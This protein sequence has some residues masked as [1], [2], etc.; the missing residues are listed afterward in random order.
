MIRVLVSGAGKMGATMV[1]GLAA[2]ADLDVAGIV[3]KLAGDT[4]FRGPSGELPLYADVHAAID[5]TKPDVVV[6]FTN[7]AWTPELTAAALPRGVR[8]VI[9]T[10]GLPQAYVDALSQECRERRVGG[11]VAA[12]FAL[13][14]VLMMH[15]AATA[16]RYFEAAEII[17]LHHDQKVDAPSGT[18][19]ATARSMLAARDGRAF[20]RNE[21]ELEPLAGARSAAV[22]GVTVHS[23]R[24]AGLVA[25]QEVIFGGRGQTLTIRHD[26]TGRDSFVPGVALAVREVMKRED[27]VVGLG[28]LL[29]LE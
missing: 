19:L 18:A 10:S 26:T 11:V 9:G 6:D 17:E 5:A 13:G 3:D 12:N 23:V 21:P 22:D 27:L 24:L 28:A 8:P 29:G 16:A 15:M 4:T 14:A 7:A 2:E 1:E 25:H 20:A